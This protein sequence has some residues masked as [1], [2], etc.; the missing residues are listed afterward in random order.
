MSYTMSWERTR[1]AWDEFDT[2]DF[3]QEQ[4]NE[5]EKSN[6]LEFDFLDTPNFDPDEIL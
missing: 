5:F 4:N 3:I 1:N 6:G 2:S